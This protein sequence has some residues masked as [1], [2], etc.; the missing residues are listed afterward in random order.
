MNEYEKEIVKLVNYS[1]WL[2]ADDETKKAMMIKILQFTN[3]YFGMDVELSFTMPEGFEAAYGLTDPETGNIMVNESVFEEEQHFLALFFF[4]HELRHGIQ[5]ARTELFSEE[6]AIN[7]NHEIQFDGT[8]YLVDGKEVI[9]VHMDGS[10]DFF[11]ELYL[12]SPAEMDAN[13]FAYDILHQVCDDKELDE[14]YRFWSPSYD[15]ISKDNMLNEFLK[16]CKQI[17]LL[18]KEQRNNLQ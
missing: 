3:D 12:G 9:T 4:L 7:C 17:D 15:I 6:I 8:G 2:S 5:K 10:Q 14:H 11:T 18:A 13:K 16:A 1:Q